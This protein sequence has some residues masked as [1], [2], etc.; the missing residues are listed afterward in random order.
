MA[1]KGP[2]GQ[3]SDARQQMDE[4]TV[5]LN[6]NIANNPP[7]PTIILKEDDKMPLFLIKLWNIVEDPNYYDVIRWDEVSFYCFKSIFYEKYAFPEWIQLSHSRSLQFLS[8]CIATV[9]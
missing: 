4:P 2:V 1:S 7:Q 6:Q 3:K 5:Q 8:Q 9:F